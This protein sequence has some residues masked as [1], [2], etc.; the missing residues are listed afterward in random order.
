MKG[1]HQ[2][3]RGAARPVAGKD[4]TRAVGSVC[5]GSQP[6]E[7][8]PRVWI[9]EAGNRSPPVRVLPIGALLVPGNHGTVVP[10]TFALAAVDDGGGHAL[11]AGMNDGNVEMLCPRYSWEKVRRKRLHQKF[12]E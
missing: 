5:G 9:A 4:A 1:G 12:T 7:K 3:V 6:H 10:Q 11:E 2:K 8:D